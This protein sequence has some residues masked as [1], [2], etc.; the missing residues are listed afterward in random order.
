VTAV[1]HAGVARGIEP[2][3]IVDRV[4]SGPLD[5]TAERELGTYACCHTSQLIDALADANLRGRGGAG[6]PSHIKWRAVASAGSAVVV[7]NGE[8]GEPASFKDRWLMLNRPH[9]IL[10]GLLLAAQTCGASRAIV[11]VS[12]EQAAASMTAAIAEIRQS[13]L[14]PPDLRL[15]VVKVQSS[16][17]AGEET[18]ACRA[19][20]GGPALPTSKPPRPCDSGVGGLPTLVSNV[21]TLVH[22]AWIARHGAAAYRQHGTSESPGTTLI[23]LGG[24]CARPGVYEVEYGMTL[25]DAFSE[26]GG[27]ISGEP[28]ALLVGGWFGGIL[29]T[30]ALALPITFESIREFGSGLGCGAFTVLGEASDPVAVVSGIA[31]WYSRESAGQCGICVKGTQAIA[32]ALEELSTGAN[33]PQTLISLR[34]WGTTLRGRGACALLDGAATLARTV[35]ENLMQSQMPRMR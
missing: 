2:R 12:D 22:A 4:S 21:E 13:E 33:A 3:L 10:D 30:N 9:S 26:L 31:R 24:D 8:E 7:A 18:A 29:P 25:A 1:P 11:Y 34:R 19:I 16:Y 23:T 17:V 20:D 28:K 35:A 27:G 15:E 5:L 14:V 6:F 32:S